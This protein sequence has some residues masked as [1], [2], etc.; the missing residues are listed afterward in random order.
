MASVF[1]V[2]DEVWE[3]VEP[4]LP[5]VEAKPTGRPRVPDRVAF[6]AIVFV[7]V[8]G[9]AWRFVPRELGCSGV[10]AWRRLRDW[11]QAGVWERL[12]A[13][14]LDQLNAA[15]AIDWSA[16]VVD[17]VGPV[18]GKIGRP[19]LRADELIADRGYDHDKYRRALRARGVKPV[20]ARRETEHG[21]GLGRRRW[22]VERTFAWLHFFR[23]LRLR[24]ERQPGLHHAFLHL[25]CAI[26]C[27]RYLRVL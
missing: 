20:I 23:P 15:G 6:N 27:E 9:I 22:V 10:T 1:E 11:Q 18:R 16:S 2:R 25:G 13:A 26:V 3:V 24:C 4:L 17:G 7:L 14:L 19:R 12:H 8:T 21:S 5:A